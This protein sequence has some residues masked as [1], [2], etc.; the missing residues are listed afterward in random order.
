MYCVSRVI[1][2]FKYAMVESK[3]ARMYYARFIRKLKGFESVLVFNRVFIKIVLH[4]ISE[5]F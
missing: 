1:F 3:N 2:K 5:I 4:D